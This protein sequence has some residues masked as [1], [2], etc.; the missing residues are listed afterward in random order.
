MKLVIIL[1]ILV[2][3]SKFDVIMTNTNQDQTLISL[4]RNNARLPISELA[5]QLGVSRTAAQ[6]RL[7]RLERTGIIKGYTI[8]LSDDFLKGSIKAMVMI[9][10]PPGK[11]VSIDRALSKIP[12]LITLYSISGSF[13]IIAVVIAP[14][15]SEL[16]EVIDQIGILEGGEE[17]QSS[18]ILSTKFER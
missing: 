14:S 5:R 10:A 16:D 7:Q 13:D 6:A 8:K 15:V 9:K 3:S 17:T 12:Q 1:I 2:N 18:V 11:R 4:L